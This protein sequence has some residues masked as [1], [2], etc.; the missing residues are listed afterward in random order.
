M[1]RNK[2]NA[3]GALVVILF[4]SA[5]IAG[6]F[7]LISR[8]A[9]TRTKGEVPIYSEGLPNSWK[10]D[11]AMLKQNPNILQEVMQEQFPNDTIQ[12]DED[13]DPLYS[14][15]VLYAARK[16]YLQR[17]CL[18]IGLITLLVLAIPTGIYF[19]NQRRK[20]QEDE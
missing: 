15:D 12:K 5:V 16:Q 14:G 19:I 8:P 17:R 18:R 4:L 1:M 10:H 20:E 6:G 11:A 13:G 7:Y 2:F 3:P 9:D